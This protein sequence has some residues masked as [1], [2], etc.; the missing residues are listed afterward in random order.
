MVHPEF[1]PGCEYVEQ[2]QT[3]CE[4]KVDSRSIDLGESQ[5]ADRQSRR[6]HHQEQDVFLRFVGPAV[7]A[8]ARCRPA[9]RADPLRT[10]WNF[11]VLG[12]VGKRQ[13][14]HTDDD[15]RSSDYRVRGFLRQ[16]VAPCDESERHTI[17]GRSPVRVRKS[18]EQASTGLPRPARPQES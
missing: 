16:S 8:R 14:A 6:T 7:R 10:K 13:H 2:Q 12:I 9:I 15:V 17:H 3:G 18:P 1:R 5:P 4:W 11:P